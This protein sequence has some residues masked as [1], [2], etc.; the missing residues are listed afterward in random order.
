MGSVQSKSFGSI[1]RNRA[2]IPDN[3]KSL[4]NFLYFDDEAK[5]KE[6]IDELHGKTSYERQK[7]LM[8]TK[9][10]IK[11]YSHLLND[12]DYND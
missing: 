2:N 6:F 9:K 10:L 8:R 4:N 1:N 3:T 7:Q 11:K 5:Y 12:F